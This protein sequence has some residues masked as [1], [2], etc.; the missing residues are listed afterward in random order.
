MSQTPDSRE[1]QR[2]EWG[3]QIGFLLAAI[4]SAIGLG[5]IWRFPGVAYTNGGGAFMVPYIVALLTAGIPILLLDYALGHRYRGS[6]PT[7]FRRL[8]KKL[9]W[10]GWWQ[11]GVCFVI[12]TYYAVIIA[13]SLR[14]VFYSF[15][16][17]WTS[18]PDGAAGFF[19]G[20]FIKIAD[21]P[22][23]SAQ[24]VWNVF[25]PLLVI[26]GAVLV[27][28]A[29]GVTAGV[30]RANKIFLP[31]LAVLFLALVVRAL[32][33]P[34]SL[35]GLNAL[36]TPDFSILADPKVWMAAYAQIFFSLSVGFGI[37]LTYA[38]YLKPRSNLVGTGIVAAFANSS[39]EVLAGFGVFATLGFMAHQQGVAVAD[40]EG[41]TG[42][43][44]SFITF[45]TII[46]EMPGGMIFGVMF[47]LSLTLAGLTSIISLVQVVAA[48][49]AEK[50]D[51]T[52]VRAAMVVGIPAAVI[53]LGIFATTSG[54]YALDVVDA[55]INQIGVVGSALVMCISVALVLRKLPILARHLNVVSEVGNSIGLW[56]RILVAGVVPVMLIIMLGQALITFINDGYDPSY[57]GG[58]EIV[59]GWGMLALTAVGTVVLTLAAWSKP[60]DD[61][62]PESLEVEEN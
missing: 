46:A 23:Y 8:S 20:D 9:E 42:I 60:I 47:F 22:T 18:N 61:F 26:W 40:L 6:A 39:F 48:G 53:S 52:P 56:W 57:A 21:T 24:P 58:F 28:I 33:L 4:G 2:E 11:V 32:F 45:P 7:V 17:A 30:E 34:G 41:I 49:V 15:S 44:L 36:W 12:M 62:T 38:S 25:I 16:T 10:L 29:K 3:S 59:F 51:L 50:F 14:Y 31:I 35:D 55:Y 1:H 5:N 54:L 27:I 13:W 37:M 19:F 43:S